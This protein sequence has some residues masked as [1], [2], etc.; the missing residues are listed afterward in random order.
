[1]T[2]N[3]TAS[4]SHHERD[5]GNLL[6]DRVAKRPPRQSGG[7]LCGRDRE[8]RRRPRVFRQPLRRPVVGA[9]RFSGIR[10]PGRPRSMTGL[11]A[12]GAGD[13]FYNLIVCLGA[14]R[15]PPGSLRFQAEKANPVGQAM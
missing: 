11:G 6:G 10:R 8:R 12:C 13:L 7:L 1:M 5:V 14:V 9:G 4:R 3:A 15:R 2:G